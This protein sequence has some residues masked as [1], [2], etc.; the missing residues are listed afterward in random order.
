MDPCCT[1]IPK[2]SQPTTLWSAGST[3]QIAIFPH[4]AQYQRRDFL[5]RLSSATVEQEESTFTH[6]PDYDRILLTLRG[7]MTLVHDKSA[8]LLLRALTPHAFDGAGETV[9]L[10]CVTDFNLMLRKNRCA[11]ELGAADFPPGAK[12]TLPLP[13]AHPRYEKTLHL[14]YCAEGSLTLRRGEDVFTLSRATR[15]PF[16]RAARATRS[17]PKTAPAAPAAPRGQAFIGKGVWRKHP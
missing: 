5:W 8:P 12:E 9:S 11:G 4:E 2:A 7:E 17:R 10:G 14:V 16:R 1:R 3:T 13:N 6:L 15:S